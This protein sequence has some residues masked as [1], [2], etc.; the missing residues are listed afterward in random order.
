MLNRQRG[1]PRF[2]AFAADLLDKPAGDPKAFAPP[3][4]GKRDDE[5]HPPIHPTA[6]GAGITDD[7]EKGVFELV[8]R[9][10]LA[11]CAQDATGRQTIVEAD[12]GG[13]GFTARGLIV[14]VR[15]WLDVYRWERWS[16]VQLPPFV[17]GAPLDTS[18][19][20]LELIPGRTQP[21]NLLNEAELLSKMD[22]HGIGTDATMADHIKTVLQ[23]EYATRGNAPPHL[24]KPTALGSALVDAYA[25]PSGRAFENALSFIAFFREDDAG[26]LTLQNLSRRNSRAATTPPRRRRRDAAAEATPPPRH[27]RDT[28]TTPPRR[29]RVAAATTPPRRYRKNAFRSRAVT[30][31]WAS[32]STGPN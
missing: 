7:R 3:R 12:L 17:A 32:A 31:R 24:L 4:A 19:S 11:C 21:P 15:G 26:S 18:N 14:D 9:H 10:F 28:A 29:R 23:R 13:E 22:A 1:D 6:P 2:G 16:G 30:T 25:R 8:A 5:A 20:S 27:R